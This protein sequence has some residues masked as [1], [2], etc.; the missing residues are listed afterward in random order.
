[1]DIITNFN[2]A[3]DVIDLTGMGT[4]LA[5]AGAIAATTTTIAADTIGFQSS[6]GNTF[7]YVNTSTS[8]EKLTAA[9]MKI[10]LQG[11]VSPIASSFLHA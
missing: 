8:S 10:E 9:N 11:T 6:G 1:M 2:V 5:F 7:V 4:K 3:M